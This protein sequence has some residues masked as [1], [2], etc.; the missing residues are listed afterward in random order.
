MT[1]VTE[2]PGRQAV[3]EQLEGRAFINLHSVV[4]E[5]TPF[6]YDSR[7]FPIILQRAANISS[8]DLRNT[9]VRSQKFPLYPSSSIPHLSTLRL[10]RFTIS[11]SSPSLR[12]LVHLSMNATLYGYPLEHT[13][14][15]TFLT[16]LTNC[17][18]LE[19]LELWDIGQDPPDDHRGDCELVVQ[20]PRLRKLYLE[21]EHAPVIG[22]IL[23]HI[24]F[25]E[26]ASVGVCASLA[27]G[28]R[29]PGTVFPRSTAN[30]LQ[31]FQGTEALTVRAGVGVCAP[32]SNESMFR[33]SYRTIRHPQEW[34]WSTSKTF[35]VVGRDIVVSSATWRAD[36]TDEMWEMFL[37]GLPRLERI[38]HRHY[39][40]GKGRDVI[41][42][43]VVAFS[44]P[45][46]GGPVCPQL[47]HLELPREVLTHGS[48]A[49]LLKRAL[50]ERDACGRRLKRLGLSDDPMDGDLLVVEPFRD[51]VDEV[52]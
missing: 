18:D 6:E 42:P 31:H 34:P 1:P 26:S 21:F 25:P 8:L 24:E 22:Y 23:S 40:I 14:I 37:R 2:D 15:K 43:F 32:S 52:L 5:M 4:F 39:R 35:K 36:L 47:Q 38:S 12:N 44:R 19:S 27:W 9:G 30:T 29:L 28:V 10:D 7:A 33:L 17:P 20:L 41:D 45:F 49:T 11:W 46:E 16:A 51:F 3:W 48:S 13:P 50:A